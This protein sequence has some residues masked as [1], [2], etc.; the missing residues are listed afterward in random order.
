MRV[1]ELIKELRK[2]DKDA[3]VNIVYNGSNYAVDHVYDDDDVI[4]IYA[5]DWEN[6]ERE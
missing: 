6:D 5:D 3:Q 2:A 4:L 1:V